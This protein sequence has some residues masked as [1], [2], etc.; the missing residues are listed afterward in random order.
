MNP[1]IF[2]ILLHFVAINLMRLILFY[3]RGAE[4]LL[5]DLPSTKFYEKYLFVRYWKDKMPTHAKFDKSKMTSL[6]LDYLLKF[7]K[8]NNRGFLVHSLPI[9]F[10]FILVCFK[11]KY[12]ILF[13]ILNFLFNI[14]FISILHNNNIKLTKV[15]SLQERRLSKIN[16]ALK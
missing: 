12:S 5:F 13:L 3:Y 1:L 16:S 8:E 4:F 2:I 14:G 6:D 7:K 11:L 15:I 10:S 9:V